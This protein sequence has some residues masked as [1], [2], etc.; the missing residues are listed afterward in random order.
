MIIKKY[1]QNWDIKDYIYAFIKFILIAVVFLH[2]LS[3]EVKKFLGVIGVIAIYFIVVILIANDLWRFI[4]QRVK[5]IK[6]RNRHKLGRN[7]RRI[8]RPFEFLFFL[9]LFSS[10]SY[11]SFAIIHYGSNDPEE[12][13]RCIHYFALSLFCYFSA[14]KCGIAHYFHKIYD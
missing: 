9:L 13:L 11:T 10:T 6:I 4:I 1:M 5:T 12:F 3:P 8:G 7:R 2:Y 14:F